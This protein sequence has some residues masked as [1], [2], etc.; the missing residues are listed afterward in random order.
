[1]SDKRSDCAYQ[2]DL[3]LLGGAPIFR[4]SGMQRYLSAT[5]AAKETGTFTGLGRGGKRRSNVGEVGA[6][7]ISTTFAI[8][9]GISTFRFS[10]LR[11]QRIFAMITILT[12]SSA[13]VGDLVFLPPLLATLPKKDRRGSK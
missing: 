12:L 13:L 8:V 3:V 4:A 6:D 2:Q 1:M 5:S 9:L 10:C 11:E 7:L